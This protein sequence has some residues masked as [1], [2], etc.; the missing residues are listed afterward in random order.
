MSPGTAAVES[1][2][3]ATGRL[4]R[5]DGRRRGTGAAGAAVVAAV[6]AAEVVVAAA[7][8]F[9][10]VAIAVA[11]G[12]D[13]AGGARGTETDAG[14]GAGGAAVVSGVGCD[15][16]TRVFEACLTIF[17]AGA[18]GC[19]DLDDESASAK[20]RDDETGC[21]ACDRSTVGAD[22]PAVTGGAADVT[23]V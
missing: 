18:G 9:A 14:V 16:P 5:H 13:V 15:G 7:R 11:E 23:T 21:G 12:T 10:G 20:S 19:G 4:S 6:E 3:R 8:P 1:G 2:D 22:G 17:T